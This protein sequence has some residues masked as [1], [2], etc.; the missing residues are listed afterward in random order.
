MRVA[1]LAAGAG[2]MY[3][4][5]CLR[6]NLLAATL[7]AAGRDIVLVPLYTPLRTDTPSVAD[8]HVYYGGI[9]VYLQ[10]KSWLF[11]H[12]PR[13]IDNLL[14]SPG[15]LRRAMRMAG[16][17]SSANLGALTISVLRGEE[18]RQAKELDKLVDGLRELSPELVNLPNLM[19]VGVARKLKAA[20]GVPVLCTLGGED[21]FLDKLLDADRQ[22]AERIIRERAADVDGF[23]AVSRYYGQ[24]MISR[25]GLEATRVH[26]VPLGVAAETAGNDT[27]RP[28]DPFRVGYL[29]R[30]C[31]DKGLHV[32][33]EAF[34]H[35]HRNG[36]PVRL[37][38]AGYLPP[39]DA[40][41]LDGIRREIEGAGLSSHFEHVGEVDLEGK[42]RFLS[43]LHVLSVPT[44]YRESKGLPVL[45]AMA[46]G[47][48]VVQP[49]HGSFPELIEA[50]GGGLLFEPN[51]H[52]ALAER[53]ASL[54]DDPV[55]R[56]R[57]GVAG[58]AAVRELFNDRRMADATWEVYRGYISRPA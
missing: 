56:E 27:A 39:E 43:S 46:H 51:D 54:M 35:L 7:L 2:G 1:Y 22:E 47:V 45:E 33:V 48:P 29:A 42:R 24:Q 44:V 9:N 32:L 30:I 5:S 19:F 14:D 34:Q 8:E 53:I 4:G 11:R 3:C 12:T 38:V 17:T 37:A 36:R 20:L 58:R 10:Q 50:T 55:R 52:V 31:H 6:D 23:I 57:L 28:A 13:V 41:Y 15:L 25:F 26:V 16:N 49:A 40:G 21:L 18:G